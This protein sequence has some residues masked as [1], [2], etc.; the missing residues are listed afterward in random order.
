MNRLQPW[1]KFLLVM[2]VIFVLAVGCK[3]KP[4]PP[5][6]SLD[7]VPFQEMARIAQ[8]AD[9]VNNLFLIDD[10]LVFWEIRGLCADAS[11]SFML[12]GSDPDELLCRYNDSIAGPQI[13]CSD[14]S[15]QALF[16]TMIEH[17]EE[18]DLGIG[19]QHTVQPIPF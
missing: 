5:A 10:S 4:A 9:E 6:S 7:L 3:A 12:F 15:Y 18:P 16:D 19:S 8:C 1:L 14:P 2:A 11:Y 17:S 13:D